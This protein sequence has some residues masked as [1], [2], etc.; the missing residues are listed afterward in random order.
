M[1]KKINIC[2][3]RIISLYTLIPFLIV[4][5]LYPLL[6]N[7]LNYPNDSI[8]NQFQINIDGLTYT[9]QNTLLIF[10]ILFLS[11]IILFIR[12]YHMYKL[13]SKLNA[14]ILSSNNT[15][16]TLYK[17]RALC[18]NTPYL[19]YFLEILIPLIFLPLTFLLF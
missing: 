19:L 9:Q 6:P 3:L 14:N 13:T 11:L 16:K 7:I 15:I 2:F 8:D 1:N 10:L 12:A 17:L 5:I 18:Y 4:I